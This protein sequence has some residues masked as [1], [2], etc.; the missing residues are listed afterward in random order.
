MENSD[1]IYGITRQKGLER[2]KSQYKVCIWLEQTD[3]LR[4]FIPNRSEIRG[5]VSRIYKDAPR[6]L[7]LSTLGQSFHFRCDVSTDLPSP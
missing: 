7:T 1:T 2:A 5:L 3:L 6:G 4:D